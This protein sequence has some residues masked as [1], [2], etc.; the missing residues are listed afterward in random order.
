LFESSGRRR[1]NSM[2]VEERG[3]GKLRRL[4]LIKM[5]SATIFDI[6]EIIFQVLAASDFNLRADSL[7]SNLERKHR[8][9]LGHSGAL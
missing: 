4:S 3:G 8:K 2:R 1:K 6:F 7:I 9:P 5:S